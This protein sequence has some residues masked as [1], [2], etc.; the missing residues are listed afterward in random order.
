[1]L[2]TRP[3]ISRRLVLLFVFLLLP[4]IAFGASVI[5]ESKN[6]LQNQ[7]LTIAQQGLVHSK[8]M[9]E[10][11]VISIQS[12]L[13]LL[14]GNA[15]YD[16]DVRSFFGY[17]NYYNRRD[18]YLTVRRI[19]T[20]LKSLCLQHPIIQNL[21][22]YYITYEESIS[23]KYGSHD[24][25]LS[26]YSMYIDNALPDTLNYHAEKD[27]FYLIQCVPTSQP[28]LILIAHLSTAELKAALLSEPYPEQ[29]TILNYGD[30]TKI[31]P[32]QRE[33]H[34]ETLSGQAHETIRI[35]SEILNSSFD[36]FLMTDEIFQNVNKRL[37]ML[38]AYIFLCIPIVIVY[39]VSIRKSI[40]VPI[41]NLI[42]AMQTT[43]DGN[44]KYRIE[45]KPATQEFS[46]LTDSLNVMMDQIES[47]IDS[48]YKYE[49]YSRKLELKHLQAQINPHFLYNTL[50]ILRHMIENEDTDNATVLCTYL[51]DY[52]KYMSS[53][54]K[55]E[56]PLLDEYEHAKNYLAIQSMRFGSKIATEL[57]PLPES[58]KTQI[59]P[60]LVIQPIYENAISYAQQSDVV[61]RV[62]T[63]FQ[64][65][66]DYLRICIED[67]GKTLDDAKLLKIQTALTTQNADGNVTALYNIQKRLHLFYEQNASITLSRSSLGG[68]CV[69]LRLP[70]QG[71][72]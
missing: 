9:L 33:F 14:V 53:T 7:V 19:I 22:I 1:M 5:Q 69:V 64:I 66:A 38:Y 52:F 29:P 46:L 67:N 51:G 13:R 32:N 4:I 70:K 47:L 41:K 11:E 56:I 31:I 8:S 72:A 65:D 42:Y 16:T 23:S 6:E 35:H 68:L 45:A 39:F 3:T 27:E 2:R 12:D 36:K 34:Y 28:K 10:K 63:T 20:K 55:L 49:I 24:Y 50:Y 40:S 48:N 17:Y 60:R 18:Y 57:E 15:N 59:V 30:G 21:E 26:A 71:G 54:E 44:L 43:R 37:Q 61:L 62:R 25:P 58:W